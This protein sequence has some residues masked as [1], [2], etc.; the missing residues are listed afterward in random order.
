VESTSR[1]GAELSAA[2]TEGKGG[3]AAKR[4]CKFACKAPLL[5]RQTTPKDQVAQA[6]DKKPSERYWLSA[7][8]CSATAQTF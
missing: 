6:C 3:V 5:E 8:Q 4:G 2:I 1:L 7:S